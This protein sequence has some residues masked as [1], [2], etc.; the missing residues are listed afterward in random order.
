ML[1][2]YNVIII[3]SILYVIICLCVE[4]GNAREHPQN[5]EAQ[6]Y[7]KGYHMIFILGAKIFLLR[8]THD[9]MQYSTFRNYQCW[10][11]SKAQGLQKLM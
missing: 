4:Q 3:L 8:T 10:R 11:G 7:M 5:K 6:W 2:Y 9:V 1:L